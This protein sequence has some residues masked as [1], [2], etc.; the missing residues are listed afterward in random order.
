MP[1]RRLEILAQGENVAFHRTQIAHH[2]QHFL[3]PFPQ[4]EHQAAFCGHSRPL[5]AIQQLQTPGVLRL[6]PHPPHTN[7]VPF[8]CCDS[9]CRETLRSRV[10]NA[11]RSPWKSGI[12]TSTVNPGLASRARTIVSANIAAP[13]SGNSSRFTDVITAW[14]TP[15]I[16]I[17][18][19]TRTGSSRS[20]PSG[21]PGLDR[22]ETARARADVAENHE[23]RR[24][25]IPAF[26]HVRTPRLF[27][28]RV[29]AVMVNQPLQPGIVLTGRYPHLQPLRPL[30]PHRLLLRHAC[31]PFPVRSGTPSGVPSDHVNFI[32]LSTLSRF[33][34]IASMNIPPSIPS[35][36]R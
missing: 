13:P 26:A 21:P 17:A 2:L 8:R 12:N 7:G 36:T 25:G 18:S 28:H 20:S 33:F 14:R 1:L 30:P 11:A 31:V 4:P 16:R 22:T 19:A 29:Q 15:M 3:V 24:P 32:A 34:T 23:R 9:G 35:T 27:A 6:R 10:C 5:R